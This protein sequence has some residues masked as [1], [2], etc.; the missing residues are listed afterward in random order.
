MWTHLP[1]TPS[2]LSTRYSRR[3]WPTNSA[4]RPSCPLMNKHQRVPQL[5]RQCGKWRFCLLVDYFAPC[6]AWLRVFRLGNL[7]GGI[8]PMNRMSDYS[9]IGGYLDPLLAAD[10]FRPFFEKICLDH[11]RRDLLLSGPNTLG[12][13][14]EVRPWE[15]LRFSDWSL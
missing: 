2:R 7:P 14:A 8:P 12:V 5:Q 9:C 4:T 3:W 6:K 15:L 10:L 13:A 1:T 11:Y